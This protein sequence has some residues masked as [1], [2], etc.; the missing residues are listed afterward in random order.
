MHRIIDLWL[1][2]YRPTIVDAVSDSGNGTDAVSTQAEMVVSDPGAGVDAVGV[3]VQTPAADS[4]SGSD[5]VLTIAEIIVTDSGEGA[6]SLL[7]EVIFPYDITANDTGTGSDEVEVL[8]TDALA[9]DNGLSSEIVQ[10]DADL[11][12]IE[13][14]Q[15]VDVV[16]ITAE[17][18][19]DDAGA[20]VD[21]GTIVRNVTE[22]IIID[23]G[24]C[25]DSLSLRAA[26]TIAD[27]GFGRDV[28]VSNTPTFSLIYALTAVDEIEQTLT[29]PDEV[30]QSLTAVDELEYNLKIRG[31]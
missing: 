3:D 26:L 5:A 14:A 13:T 24:T 25:L 17:I 2:Y 11:T 6:D 31:D 16:L 8:K 29:A 22:I 19:A 12:I 23:S 10:I 21:S 28:N 20:G 30:E 4:G 27:V 18:P 1:K 15:G 7:I 9:G